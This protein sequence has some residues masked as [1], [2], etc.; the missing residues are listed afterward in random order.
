MLLEQ[1][2]TRNRGGVNSL[3]RSAG[4]VRK[5]S[6]Q[7]NGPAAVRRAVRLNYLKL[8]R[9]LL[10]LLYINCVSSLSAQDDSYKHNE[11][12]KKIFMYQMKQVQIEKIDKPSYLENT[13]PFSK[14]DP[15][16]LNDSLVWVMNKLQ[17][18][19]RIPNFFWGTFSNYYGESI[20]KAQA[21]PNIFLKKAHKE[22]TRLRQHYRDND[23]LFAD[24][25]NAL[26]KSKHSVFLNLN[27]L[28]RVDS[29][30]HEKSGYWEYVI[31]KD[32][33]F[34]LSDSISTDI[35]KQFSQSDSTI[36]DLIEKLGVYSVYKD[37]D[38]IFYLVDGVL[39]NSYGFA[40]QR[41]TRGIKSDHLFDISK[42]T[43]IRDGYFF[44]VAR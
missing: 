43:E 3:Q 23:E 40:Y 21:L 39:D 8:M 7:S 1:W 10:I 35:S 22:E 26:I 11:Y 34:P 18:I 4:L 6:K 44:Y 37:D 20:K 16:P 36:F 15:R 30:Y 33:P 5:W 13:K 31:A 27:G 14:W 42:A 38:V 25:T 12:D 17:P 24:L 32:S 19:S 28:K 9:I 29:L 41:G 2:L